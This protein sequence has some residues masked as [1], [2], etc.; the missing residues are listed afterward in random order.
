MIKYTIDTA[1]EFE[2]FS[3]I[4]VSSEDD[5]ILSIAAKEGA[6]PFFR[7]ETLSGDRVR[8]W[9]TVE[10]VLLSHNI[11]EEPCMIL[12]PTS[13]FRQVQD[14]QVCYN[15]YHNKNCEA[16][17]SVSEVEKLP[18]HMVIVKDDKL[19]PLDE[20][21]TQKR[22]QDIQ[23]HYVHDGLCLVVD[24][25]A[26]LKNQEFYGLLTVPYFSPKER[27]LDLDTMLQ[28]QQAE[29]ILKEKE[30]LNYPNKH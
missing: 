10:E 28:W 17:M 6:S 18:Q 27:S 9:E 29:M 15:L 22:R 8:Y 24:T 13:P 25:G 5:E 1:K 23:K 2:L 21:G 26:F 3:D 20:A 7:S 11:I 16:V 30:N 14:L 12:L 4:I 19:V